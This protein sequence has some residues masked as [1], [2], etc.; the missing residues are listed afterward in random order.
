MK[1]A[2]AE[3]EATIRELR[4]TISPD[5]LAR[6]RG[7]QRTG[8]DVSTN[9]AAP[10]AS[11]ATQINNTVQQGLQQQ[12]QQQPAGPGDPQNQAPPNNLAQGAQQGESSPAPSRWAGRRCRTAVRPR[13]PRSSTSPAC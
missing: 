11:S 9:S 7:G 12:A 3:Q 5:D 6:K 13:S 10:A 1:R 4:N 8:A 2:L